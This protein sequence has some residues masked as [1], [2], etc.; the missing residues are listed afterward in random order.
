M[1]LLRA[2]FARCAYCKQT[3]MARRVTSHGYEFFAYGCPNRFDSCTRFIVSAEKLD[4]AVWNVVEQLA[5]HG[6]LIEKSI[7]EDLRATDAALEDWKAKVDNYEGDLEDSSL[8]GTTRAGIRHL[9]DGAQSMVEDLEKQRA[10]LMLHTVDR[11][12]A[13]AE[14]EKILDW[15]KQVKSER[16]ELSYTQKRDFLHML[17]AI[18]L[19]FKQE[20]QGA[21]PTWDIRVSLPK[22]Q[23][24]I[25][26]SGALGNSL[27]RGR[28]ERAFP[29]HFCGRIR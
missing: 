4:K 28:H 3:M 22:V 24:V 15:C 7:D 25:Y 13:R 11:D 6:A 9:L 8:R 27:S 1:F 12:K 23:E 2:G 16:A 18:V 21:E 29:R 20:Y 17:G 10:E 19:V 14:Y 26:Q 5:D